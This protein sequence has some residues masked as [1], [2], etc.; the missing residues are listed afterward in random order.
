MYETI[1]A[2]ELM[3]I[4]PIAYISKTFSLFKLPILPEIP[5]SCLICLV[6]SQ[7]FNLK[8]DFIM[9]YFISFHF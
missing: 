5:M 9:F 2:E 8:L 7:Y 6:S 3:N 1:F 4:N